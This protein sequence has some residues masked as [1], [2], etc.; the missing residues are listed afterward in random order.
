MEKYQELK[1]QYPDYVSLDQF[2]RICKIAKRSARYLVENG[3]VPVIDTGR[4][5]WRYQI[6]IDDVI[7][8]LTRRELVGSMIPPGRVTSRNSG[9]VRVTTRKSFAQIVQTGQ[10][11]DIAEYF[12]YIYADYDRV[13][14]T[15]DV[16][17]MTGLEKSSVQ[18]YLRVGYIKSLQVRPRYLIPKQYLMEFV[19]TRRYIEAKT[20]SDAFKRILGGFELW[21]AA[22]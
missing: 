5:T 1:E 19:V 6:A 18:K 2:Y 12:A 13:L 4:K 7:T 10:E 20:D 21:K 15:D 22:K 9:Y 3:I 11:K 8:Y 17:E 16:T 14:T